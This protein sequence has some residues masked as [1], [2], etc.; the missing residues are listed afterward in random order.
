MYAFI[1]VGL[2]KFLNEMAALQ[3]SSSSS[4]SPSPSPSPSPSSSSYEGLSSRLPYLLLGPASLLCAYFGLGLNLPA[5]D[6]PNEGF[7]RTIGRF[8]YLGTTGSIRSTLKRLYS[9]F[10]SKNSHYCTILQLHTMI[11]ILFDCLI[12][13]P[14]IFYFLMFCFIRCG[15]V[16]CGTAAIALR[17]GSGRPTL[18]CTSSSLSS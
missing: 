9:I 13:I 18:V 17:S 11:Y 10:A 7:N 1:Y 4:T 6:L 14:Y 3:A 5:G 16:R 15:A 12:I 2:Y 8:F